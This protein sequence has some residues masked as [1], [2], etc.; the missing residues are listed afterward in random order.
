MNLFV[1]LA[2][3]LCVFYLWTVLFLLRGLW[4]LP[5]SGRPKG[6]TY[7]VVIAA[8]NEERTIENC[9]RHV[10]AQSLPADRFEVILAADRCS[11][12]TVEIASRFGRAGKDLSILEIPDVPPGYAPKKHALTHAISRARHEIIVMTDADCTVPPAWLETFDRNF[13]LGV[14]LVQ[15]ITTYEHPGA[16]H[17]LLYGLQAVDFLSHG[18]VSAAA[19][20]AGFPLNSNAN[21]LAFRKKVFDEVGGYESVRGLVSGDDDLLLQKVGRHAP[22]KLR[23]MTDPAGAVTTLP[24]PSVEG[25]IEQRK[26]WGSKTV[27]YNGPQV[28]VL[29]GIFA[30]YVVMVT[31]FVAGLGHPPFFVPFGIMLA[32]KLSGEAL[33]MIPGT[34][35]FRQEHLRRYLIPASLL[36]LPMVVIAV[37][38]GVFGRF[39]WKGR[40]SSRTVSSPRQPN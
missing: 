37:L 3:G 33:L 28:A 23:F 27:H 2:L 4:A 6:Y 19:I 32:V 39:T 10:L 30:F 31:S 21:N 15:G 26:R 18:I 11:D 8:H 5:A 35:I 29:S 13:D 34:R 14:G 40:L 22:W 16:M 38:G 7:S 25:I 1:I 20:G 24:T 36:Q 9:L 17:P 12:A